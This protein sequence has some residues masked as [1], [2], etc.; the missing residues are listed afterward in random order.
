MILGGILGGVFTPAE[1]GVVA[2]LYVTLVSA[3]IFKSLK[4]LH[5]REILTRTAINTM[6]VS[7]LLGLAF[8]LGR[9]LIEAQ[10]PLH[11]ANTSWLWRPARSCC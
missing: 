3:F 7:Y 1:A 10:I 8:V 9:Y 11:V 6:R 2:A 4:L 5:F